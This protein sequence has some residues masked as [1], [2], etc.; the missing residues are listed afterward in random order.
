M[1]YAEQHLLATLEQCDGRCLVTIDGGLARPIVENVL[2]ATATTNHEE[3]E[4]LK[5]FNASQNEKAMPIQEMLA[6]ALLR[7][8]EESKRLES[9]Q[10]HQTATASAT[11]PCS[12]CTD[13]GP[14]YLED[15]FV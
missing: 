11:V 6:T 5:Q 8:Q 3:V 10:N 15:E 9:E 12:D 13:H 14:S 4:C 1:G 7:L 2:R